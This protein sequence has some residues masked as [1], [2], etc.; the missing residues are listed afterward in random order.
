MAYKQDFFKVEIYSRKAEVTGK[1]IHQYVGVICWFSPKRQDILRWGGRI[2]RFFDLRLVKELRLCLETWDQQKRMLRFGTWVSLSPGPS[3]RNLEQ[4]TSVRVQSSVP[5]YVM[6]VSIFH[7]AESEFLKNNSE[8]FVKML[9]LFSIG[10]NTSCG[11]DFH[12][13]LLV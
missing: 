3:G 7:L 4:R 10:S 2:Q 11:S 1:I 6:V 8:T 5:P 9:S 13:R 12:E